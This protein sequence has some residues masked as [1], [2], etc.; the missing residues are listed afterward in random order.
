MREPTRTLRIERLAE[1][2]LAFLEHAQLPDG[3]FH[4]R[5]S[6]TGAWLD[7]GGSDDASGRALWAAGTASA[8]ASVR[9]QRERA[10]RLFEAGAGFRTIWPRANAFAVLGSVE[11]LAV[12]PARASAR[13]LLEAASR[14]L[15]RLSSDPAWPWPEPRLTYAN[16]VLAEARLAAG[17]ALQDDRLLAE[18]FELLAWLVATET[19]GDHFSF[20]PTGGWTSGEPRPGFDQQPI[21]A[22][23]M[24]DACARAF[25]AS[26]TRDWCERALLAAAWFLGWNDV[27]VA[28]L[29]PLTGGCKDG[30]E[31]DGVN[32]NEGAESTIALITALQ[33]ARRLQ[34]AA[35]RAS[36]SSATSTAAAPTQRSAAP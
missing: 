34:A 15:G 36:T 33:Q 18:G 30:L 29:D 14:R 19:R 10:L 11:V 24:V 25:D 31:R 17:L 22:A 9:T 27:G 6:V 3:R 2:C 21:E 12:S 28:L 26:G 35:R 8:A 20:V 16:A 23:A 13:T 5:L 7:D 4:N 32:E 1:R